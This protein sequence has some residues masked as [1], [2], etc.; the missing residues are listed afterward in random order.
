MTSASFKLEKRTKKVKR[1]GH[2]F[3]PNASQKTTIPPTT[4]TDRKSASI[5]LAPRH[6]LVEKWPWRQG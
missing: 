3:D 5:R 1:L 2:H 4:H 6:A